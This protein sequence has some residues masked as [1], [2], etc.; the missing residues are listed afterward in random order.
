MKLESSK[1]LPV[2]GFVRHSW[3]NLS[4]TT[5]GEKSKLVDIW[6]CFRRLNWISECVPGLSH[7]VN[8]Q[9]HLQGVTA[10][11]HCTGA[12]GLPS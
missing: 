9:Q 6:L 12:R 4:S 7:D 11:C 8:V 10:S 2:W 1:N 3:P 5:K